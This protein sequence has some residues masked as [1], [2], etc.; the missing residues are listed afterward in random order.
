M[1]AVTFRFFDVVETIL[2]Q[3]KRKEAELRR[4]VLEEKRMSIVSEQTL[5]EGP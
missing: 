1:R 2:P 3:R 4:K 5:V